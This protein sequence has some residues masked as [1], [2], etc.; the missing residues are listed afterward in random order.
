MNPTAAKPRAGRRRSL[1]ATPRL[2]KSETCPGNT[3]PRPTSLARPYNP[4]KKPPAGR[5]RRA[6]CRADTSQ[7]AV[8]TPAPKP[9]VDHP[10]RAVSASQARPREWRRSCPS[11][12]ILLGRVLEQAAPF[13]G[14]AFEKFL[15]A[16][17]KGAARHEPGFME[18]PAGDDV[19]ALVGV[20][21]D[22][23]EVNVEARHILLDLQGQFFLR[24]V[25]QIQSDVIGLAL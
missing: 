9:W 8:P 12:P 10:A 21:A 1:M 5:R 22:R 24:E 6:A 19:I 13:H 14:V 18:S 17:V 4:S 20:F 7:M 16:V 11:F 3:R 2:N 15:D 23:G 25:G